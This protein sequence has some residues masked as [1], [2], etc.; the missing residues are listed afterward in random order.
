MRTAPAVFEIDD[1]ARVI[2]HGRH[3]GGHEVLRAGA[4]AVGG[5]AEPDHQGRPLARSHDAPR[6][7]VVDHTQGPRAAHALQGGAHGGDQIG[8]A[9][10]QGTVDEVG[11]DLGVGVGPKLAPG[12]REFVA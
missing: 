2:E 4:L 10:A 1:G 9:A 8:I 5:P 6:Q 3:V 12:A 7:V 11:E